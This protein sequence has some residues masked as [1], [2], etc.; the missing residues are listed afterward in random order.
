MEPNNEKRLDELFNQAK[1]EPSKVSFEKTKEQFVKSYGSITST[2]GKL[3]QFT[4]LK[5]LIMISTICAL[6]IGA[7]MLVY[8]YTTPTEIIDNPAMEIALADSAF[9]VGE[10]EAVVN[11]YINRVEAVKASFPIALLVPSEIAFQLKE[12]SKAQLDTLKS[13]EAIQKK[14]RKK[15]E[16]DTSFVFPVLNTKE[17]KAQKK[18]KASLTKLTGKG[19]AFGFV[20]VPSGTVKLNDKKVSIQSFQMKQTEVTNLQYRT[21]LFDLLEQGRKEDFLIAKPDQSR[22]MKDYPNSSNQPMEQNYFSHPAYDEYPV[23]AI[24]R[25][26]A[27]MYCAWL[28][29]E[30]NKVRISKSKTPINDVRLPSNEEW[31]YAAM[32]GIES[33]LFPW[34]GPKLSNAKGCFLANFK[35]GVGKGCLGEQ[36]ETMDDVRL[37]GATQKNIYSADGGFF[38]VKVSSYN[39]N[40]FGLYCMSGNVAE[41]V[42]YKNGNLGTKGGSWTSVGQELQ[43]I[44]GKDRFKGLTK[45]SVNV[46]FRPV[47]T[48]LKSNQEKRLVGSLGPK[49]ITVTP[50]GTVKLSPHLYFDKTEITNFNW[51]EYVMWNVRT[52]GKD[53]KEHNASLPDTLVWKSKLTY[54]EPYVQHYFNHPAYNNYPVVGITYEQV[55]AFCKWR[56]DRV[57]E[58]YEI[59]K[60]KNKKDVFPVRFEYRLPTKQEWER[61][62]NVGYSE[63]MMKKIVGKYKG[64]SL[65]N[66]KKGDGDKMGVAG[67]LNDNADV[68]APVESYFPNALGC[69]NLIG[70]VAEMTSVK[71]IAKGGSWRH[72]EKEIAIENNIKYTKQNAWIGFRCV[73]EVLE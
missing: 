55:V 15:F 70:N 20:F 72:D 6:S 41:M 1:N 16:V 23:V 40:K 63:K 67:N 24:S 62:A 21:F 54:N 65:A 42:S 17:R 9:I 13:A 11:E 39:P 7:S 49:S 46:G 57:K 56:T 71:G 4:N 18:Q 30:I 38:T 58:L 52:F 28:T 51:N 66:Y 36:T 33:N 48:H 43:I 35:P 27:K 2:G 47:I 53:S 64:K 10:H 31:M 60:N 19:E 50:P 26:G 29:E 5:T 61:I 44:D 8:N 25:I 3:T 69:Y 45:A 34:G 14:Q 37:K 68:T 12:V 22:W 59:Q 32:S 73:F